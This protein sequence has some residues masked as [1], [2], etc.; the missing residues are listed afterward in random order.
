M[1][2]LLAVDGSEFTKRMLGF[3]AAHP[4]LLGSGHVFDAL[5]VVW[6]ITPHARGFLSRQVVDSYYETSAAETLK[7]VESFAKQ[8]GWDLTPMSRV[9]NPS[10]VIAEVAASGHYDLIVMGSHGHG[11]VLGVVL[12][13]VVTSVL[14]R[15]RTPLLIVR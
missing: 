5:T 2:V 7:P 8:N 3:L 14:A 4:E 1:K 11:A 6:P 12:G 10:E 13:S 9:G 15:V